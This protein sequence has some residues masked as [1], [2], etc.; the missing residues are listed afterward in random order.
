MNT[1]TVLIAK[2]KLYEWFQGV[3]GEA[4]K[5]HAAYSWVVVKL[6][7]INDNSPQFERSHL[8]VQTTSVNLTQ[9]LFV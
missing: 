3:R 2:T 4:D 6:K 7:D 1:D 9:P 5:N 8:E